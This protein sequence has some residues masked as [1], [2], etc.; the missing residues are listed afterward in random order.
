VDGVLVA[1][2]SGLAVLVELLEALAILLAVGT[3]RSWRDAW[4][5]AA[6]A[7]AACAAVAVVL[8]PVL[9]ERLGLTALRLVIGAALLWFGLNWLRKNTLRLAGRKKRSS[10]AAE[11]E[12]VRAEVTGATDWVAFA[13]AFKGVF[14]EGLEIVLI[15]SVLAGRPS[16][17]G[18][19]IAGA[20]GAA[21][22]V[23]VAGAA[24]RRP[25]ARVP[26]T[27]LKFAV[28]VLLT[29]FGLF[30]VG[31]G[32]GVEWPGGDLA[33]LYLLLAVLA[34]ASAAVRALA[35]AVLVLLAGCGEKREP[36][37]PP[38]AR[39]VSVM[40]D[41]AELL[42]RSPEQIA[43]TLDDMKGLG[44]DW[45]R[46]TAG[47]D[48][49]EPARGTFA[50]DALD[51]VAAL[52]RERGLELN[53]DIAFFK[54]GWAQWRD[55]ADFAKAVA[56]RYPQAAAFTVWNE[57]NLAVFM[58]PQWRADGSPLAPDIYRRMLR[59]A[60][61]AIRGAAPG[62]KVLIGATSSLGETSG[63]GDTRT[64][65]LTFL[66]ALCGKG[67]PLPGDGWSH[68][69]YAGGL[70]PWQHDPLP[71]T[72]RIGDLDRLAAALRELRGCFEEGPL[73]IYLTEYGDQTNPPDPTWDITPDEQARR[74]AEAEEIARAQPTVRSTAQFL[75]RD[76]PERPGDDVR[77]R[78]RDYQSGLRFAGGR[79]KP[80]HAAYA[81]PL[82]AH[83]TASGVRFWGLLRAGGEAARILADGRPIAEVEP[84]PDGTFTATVETDPDATFVLEADGHRG[85]P[86]HG[87]R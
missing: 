76:L 74:L 19:A 2:G 32:L 81:L 17:S 69:P 60:V 42:H 64:A 61:P 78:W 3:S 5:G 39:V 56:R 44:V 27:E 70:L 16:G 4:L 83:R 55:Y 13:V 9:I 23:V 8:G 26:E 72:V 77:T 15:V 53:V 65:P 12:E 66:R 68:H 37:P 59:S 1:I 46:V 62:A 52:A 71:A 58:S 14:L 24:L 67:A 35:L 31:E 75:M 57:P 6:A 18:P 22:L 82:T 45:V 7:T 28:G 49:V 11:F 34:A 85:A 48:V 29:T 41:D 10:S 47:W 63:T 21:V 86:L 33:L 20:I 54:P 36:K 87:A 80:A 73:P 43:A 84:G 50:W 79:A 25:L 40:Q 30:F 38:A 51:R